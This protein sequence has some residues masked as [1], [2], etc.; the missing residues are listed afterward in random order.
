MKEN[1]SFSQ[2]ALLVRILVSQSQNQ[3]LTCA[4]ENRTLCKFTID[5]EPE[6]SYIHPTQRRNNALMYGKKG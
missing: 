6:Y 4:E 2:F 5:N 1:D 3:D